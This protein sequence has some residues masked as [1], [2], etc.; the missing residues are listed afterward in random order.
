[1]FIERLSLVMWIGH[2]DWATQVKNS[3]GNAL[4]ENKKEVNKKERGDMQYFD[5]HPLIHH[6]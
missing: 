3:I 2:I 4:S 6:P 5:K 1:M